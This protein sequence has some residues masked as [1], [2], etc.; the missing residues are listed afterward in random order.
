MIWDAADTWSCF[1]GVD[2]TQVSQ[3]AGQICLMGD[4][5]Q[6]V[7]WIATLQLGALI[8][9][10][11]MRKASFAGTSGLRYRAAYTQTISWR[12]ELGID[13]R[14]ELVFCTSIRSEPSELFRRT[15]RSS[16]AAVLECRPL[17]ADSLA[18]LLTSLRS[19]SLPSLR[20]GEVVDIGI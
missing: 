11:L 2:Q 6:D 13:R 14:D 17:V 16:C 18:A 7:V 15:R 19:N 20:L 9:L 3:I 4:I 10:L 1:H 5:R 8:I 12:K